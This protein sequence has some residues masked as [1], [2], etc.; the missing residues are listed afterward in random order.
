VQSAKQKLPALS[1]AQV[2]SFSVERAKD[3]T[4]SAPFAAL[5]SRCVGV[6][7]PER[8]QRGMRSGSGALAVG[9]EIP[10]E[11]LLRADSVI[12]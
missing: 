6:F 11:V 5:Q 3:S 10:L 4:L 1:L 12:K 9:I 8:K 7:S 2:P